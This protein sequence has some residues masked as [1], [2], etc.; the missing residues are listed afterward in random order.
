MFE[1]CG[2]DENCEVGDAVSRH[3]FISALERN[4]YIVIRVW[5][6]HHLTQYKQLCSIFNFGQEATSVLLT[7]SQKVHATPISDMKQLLILTGQLK[8]VKLAASCM[9]S[10]SD[11]FNAGMMYSIYFPNAISLHH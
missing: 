9:Y 1:T 6:L 11:I 7:A 5:H 2:P 3:H 4:S 10:I 8:Y